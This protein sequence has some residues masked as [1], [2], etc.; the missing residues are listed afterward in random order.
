[1]PFGKLPL[2]R[3]GINE[4]KHMI[5]HQS[6]IEFF[7]QETI[8]EKKRYDELMAL[9]LAERVRKRRAIQGLHIDKD[10]EEESPDGEHLYRLTV[11]INLA[12]FKEGDRLRLHKE[13]SD[14]GVACTLYRFEGDNA[15]LISVSSYN[16]YCDIR[17]WHGVALVLDKD[18]VDLRKNVYNPF[19]TSLDSGKEYWEKN[20]LNTKQTPVFENISRCEKELA[21][22][23]KCFHL[24]FT[25]RQREAILRSMEAKDY[26]LIQG[27]PGTGKSF[28][29][30]WI[31][32]EELL[33]F[34]RKVVVVGPNHLAINNA[35]EQVVKSFPGIIS[36]V[37]KVGQSYNA[38]SLQFDTEK[39]KEGIKN[40]QRL[41]CRYVNDFDGPILLG[42]TPHC[43]YTSRA[44]DLDVDVLVIDEAGQM[45]IPLA[46]MGMIKANKVIM[47]GDH[48]QLPPIVVSDKIPEELKASVFQRIMTPKNATLLDT[49]FRMRGAVCDFVSDLFY[50]SK[51]KAQHKE[52]GTRIMGKEALYS[53]GHPVI[54]Q[55]VE[56]QGEQSSDK[57]AAFIANTIAGF[58]ERGLSGSDIAVLSPF[59]AQA[60]NIRKHIRKSDKIQEEDKACVAV[61]TIDKMQGQERE[62]I[63]VSLVA[64]NPDYMDEI[65]DFLYNPNK[66]NV[67][68]SRAKSKLIVV[69]NWTELTL[70]D[71]DKYPLIQRILDSR[72]AE[73]TW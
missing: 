60:A 33:F 50:E 20:I 35:L 51:V 48:K 15:I 47:A 65:G 29:L 53:F 12:D 13:D 40:V 56:D 57:E 36:N 17:D 7:D 68:F 73:K 61:D 14:N 42:M 62:V 31:I 46:L 54:L 69:G 23:E 26:Y 64:G 45:P 10:Y 49:S 37:V 41:N 72:F 39:G 1:M 32:L 38:P 4:K 22:T 16:L 18:N 43:L 28:V 63:I 2:C 8:A 58:M 44:R 11:G 3:F 19:T 5:T 55:N 9:S 34:K 59:R 70:L 71:S 24:K 6:I 25:P 21:D 67:A 30:G 52:N 66:L 27:P